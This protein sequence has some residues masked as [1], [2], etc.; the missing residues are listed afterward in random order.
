MR[1]I[2]PT[3]I[4]RLCE[5]KYESTP[6]SSFLALPQHSALVKHEYG[7]SIDCALW[8]ISCRFDVGLR[9]AAKLPA[10]LRRTGYVNP[11]DG[12]AGVLQEY[13]GMN[14]HYFDLVKDEPREFQN[15]HA[16]L[17]AYRSVKM[18]WTTA[19]PVE[20]IV[21]QGLASDETVTI[22]DVG[23]GSGHDLELLDES[24]RKAPR[25]LILQDLADVTKNIR[26]GS[27]IS[28]EPQ[29]HN[30]FAPQPVHGA[31]MYVLKYVLHDWP[32]AKAIEILKQI[33][34]A[35]E[36][37]YSKI[38]VIDNVISEGAISMGTAGLDAAMMCSLASMERTER[39]W[40]SLLQEAGLT[41]RSL[42]KMDDGDGLI[43]AVLTQDQAVAHS[44]R[45]IS[46]IQEDL[47][48]KLRALV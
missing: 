29:I 21:Y 44:E 12:E 47:Q 22:V 19:S 18:P 39:Q 15:M 2:E 28:I 37:E 17:A 25:R 45:R 24:F 11:S 7:I 30:F 8:L 43:E 38:I 33:L 32:D 6:V 13:T 31:R 20:N 9:L 4:V 27:L 41:V 10:Y 14:S 48:R 46:Q 35:M 16:A 5:D 23:G 40:R 26:P 1:W 34:P 36:P 42:H 3:G